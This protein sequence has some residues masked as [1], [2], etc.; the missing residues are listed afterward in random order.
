MRYWT[1]WRGVSS[2]GSYAT[3]V[4]HL[5]ATPE[6]SISDTRALDQRHDRTLGERGLMRPPPTTS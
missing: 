2:V 4:H 5:I 1:E 6:R 3:D